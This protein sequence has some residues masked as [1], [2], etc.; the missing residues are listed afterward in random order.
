MDRSL[1]LYLVLRLRVNQLHQDAVFDKRATTQVLL[2]RAN[3]AG[4]DIYVNQVKVGQALISSGMRIL[5]G[6][7]LSGQHL[8]TIVGITMKLVTPRTLACSMI[9]T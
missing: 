3:F 7:L 5:D 4:P 6:R 8:H 9:V 2:F 1:L